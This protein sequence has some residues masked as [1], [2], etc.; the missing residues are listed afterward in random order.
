MASLSE[1]DI[2]VAFLPFLREFYRFRYEYQ[3]NTEQSSLDNVTADGFIAD[4]MLQFVKPDGKPFLCTYEA[5]S[6]DKIG[7]VKYTLNQTYFLWDCVAFA[8]F[9]T[10]LLMGAA[11]SANATFLGQLSI[12]GKIGMPLGMMLIGFFIWYFT[13]SGWKKY[14]HIFA[15]EQFKR[16]HADEQW[17]AISEDVFPAPTSPFF[18]E[19]KDQCI[20]QGVG[21]AVVHPDLQVRMLAAPSRLGVFGGNRRM[22]HWITDTQ[23]YQSMS[24]NIKAAAAYKTPVAGPISKVRNTLMRPVQRYLIQPLQRALGKTVQPTAAEVYKQFTEDYLIQKWV[25][26]ISLGAIV[27]VAVL[28][29]AKKPVNEAERLPRI[30]QPE[31]AVKSPERQDGFVMNDRE[32]AIPYGENYRTGLPLGTPRQEEID[33]DYSQAEPA[34]GYGTPANPPGTTKPRTTTSPPTSTTST[35]K[36]TTPDTTKTTLATAAKK[37]TTAATTTKTIATP[38][39]NDLCSKIKKA[40][41]WYIQDNLFSTQGNALDRVKTLKSKGITCEAFNASCLGE[42]GWVVRIGYN[43]YSEA[44]ARTKA[45]AY[46]KTLVKNGLKTGKIIIKKAE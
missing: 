24:S 17:V 37:A 13:M 36:T 6:A 41:G 5:T 18:L 8:A 27:A 3:S 43:Q 40:G 33:A 39:T 19:L 46:E 34:P 10:A 11:W 21:L 1:N 42:T 31:V 38:A 7:E 44:A 2:K 14:R 20:Y 29:R 23:F 25:T 15:I 16:Y 28:S 12:A 35:K 32:Q 45:S 9:A 26:V 30:Y 22:A 4:G